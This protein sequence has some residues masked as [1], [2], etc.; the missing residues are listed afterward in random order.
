[1]EWQAIVLVMQILMLAVGWFLFQQARGELSA[2]AAETPVLGEVKALQRNI[3][4]LLS[5]LERASERASE[6]SEQSSE[7]LEARCAEA[8]QLI[9]DLDERLQ[10]FSAVQ[11]NSLRGK[12]QTPAA[13]YDLRISGEDMRFS[14]PTAAMSALVAGGSHGSPAVSALAAASS[15]RDLRRENVFAL[16]D[17]GSIV[18]RYSP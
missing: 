10:E 6:Q 2:R 12:R 9:A 17:A 15:S 5:D 4:Q 14:E 1:M 7:Q 11:E 16:A 18:Q 13:S 8:R 3:K